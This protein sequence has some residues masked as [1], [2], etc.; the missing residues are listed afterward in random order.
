[1]PNSLNRV[2][3]AGVGYSQTGRRLNLTNDEMVRQSVTAAMA[4][5]GMTPADIDG[6]ATMGGEAMSMGHLLGL[7][8]LSYFFTSNGG[9]AFIEPAMNAY[10]AVA[11]GVAHT[12]VAVRL[13]RQQ[14]NQADRNSG[15]V[16]LPATVGGDAQFTS[17]FGADAGAAAMI[18]GLEMT[19]HMAKFGTTEEQFALNAVTQRYHA[20]LNDDAL[21]RDPLTVEDYLNSRFVSKPVRIF[22][23]DYPVDSSSA[24]IFTTVERAQD[25][26]HKPVVIEAA[27]LS[28]LRDMNFF[29]LDDFATTSPKHCS[30]LLWS[31][32]DLTPADVDCA[33]LYDG[34]SIITLQWLEA[35]GFCG[36]G[37]S[38]AFVE[39]GHT[40]LGG[41]L[42]TNTD[43]GACNVGRRHG[44]N[45][46]IESVRQIRG[47]CGDRQVP[48]AEV[49][50]W[51]NAVGPFS[52]A[53]LLT[54]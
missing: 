30:D 22:D 15:A 18:A 9:P 2:A 42:P 19:A 4:D 43:G 21:L 33:Q 7:D 49:A 51:T 39:A 38:G 48:G 53:M 5:A 28:S 40:R 50:V 23:C 47:D 12:V 11:S 37:E 16:T 14:P 1:M 35:L 44:A 36:M 52:G 17:P 45:F 13:I 24:V 25:W 20:S 31:R 29:Q 26:Q 27:A 54:A 10:T 6:V 34:F 32:T 8:P 3:I 46:C 41:S